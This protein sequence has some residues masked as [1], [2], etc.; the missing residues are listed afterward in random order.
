MAQDGEGAVGRDIGARVADG[1]VTPAL[2][3]FARTSGRLAGAMRVLCGNPAPTELAAAQVDFRKTVTA[4]GRVSVLRFGPLTAENRF[5]RIYF[6]PDVRGVTLRQV[7]GF[8]ASEEPVSAASLAERSVALQGLPALE[9]VLFGTGAETLGNGEGGNGQGGTRRC[10]YGAA[11]A[12]NVAGIAG[13]I[14]EL[15]SEG[16]DFHVS[17]TAPGPDM[18]PYR[19]AEEVAGEIVKAAGTALEFTRNAELLPALGRANGQAHGR[20]AP[21]W[22]SEWTF[23]LVAAQLSAVE[24]LVREA[25][26]VEG[27]DETVNGYG[28]SMLFDI[29]HA[30]AALE[31][32]PLAPEHAFE[33]AQWRARITYATVALEGAKHTLNGQLAG[34]LGLVM[35]FNALDGD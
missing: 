32:V 5:E 16:G 1:F 6:W 14:A 35:G 2:A 34:A 8:L 13:E 33:E 19:S 18:N 7:Q 12:D 22:R 17:F 25:G 3:D 10:A 15:W 28:R 30:R 31:A 11:I 9:Y 26:F 23:G 27:P 4:W 20:R 24:D 29:G 21:F